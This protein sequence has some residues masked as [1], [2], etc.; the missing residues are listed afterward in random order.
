MPRPSGRIPGTNILRYDLARTTAR[1][2]RALLSRLHPAPDAGREKRPRHPHSPPAAHRPRRGTGRL[3]RISGRKPRALLFRGAPAS[4]PGHRLCGLC[5]RGE[6]RPH[7]RVPA[8]DR[9]LGR[10]RLLLLAAALD[11]ARAH[12][13]VHP[14]LFPVGTRVRSAF[15]RGHGPGQ[16]HRRGAPRNPPR[17]ARRSAPRGLLRPHGRGVGPFDVLREVPAAHLRLP[18]RSDARRLDLQ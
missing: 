4:R 9:Q 1:N 3:A 8:D 18:A 5:A 6:A 2:G 13:A 17:T 14:A 16:L 10:V 15:R 12:V 7:G 11:G